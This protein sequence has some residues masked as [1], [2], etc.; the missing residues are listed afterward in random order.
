VRAAMRDR[1]YQATPLGVL[2][3]RYLRWLRNEW[4]ATAST[5]RDYEAILARMAIMPADRGHG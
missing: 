5:V 3:G 4:G 2:V 1:S